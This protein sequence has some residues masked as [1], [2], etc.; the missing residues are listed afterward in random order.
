MQA[1]LPLLLLFL[2]PSVLQPVNLHGL[3]VLGLPPTSRVVGQSHGC[4]ID[5]L[6]GR[7]THSGSISPG[8]SHFLRTPPHVSGMVWGE[9]FSL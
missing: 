4:E 6:Q 9:G 5:N 8:L 2:L 3:G 7:G 1:V